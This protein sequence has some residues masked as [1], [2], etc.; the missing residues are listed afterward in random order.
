MKY[1]TSYHTHTTYCDGKS[2][3]QEMVLAAIAKGF[4]HLGFASHAPVGPG[5]EEDMLMKKEAFASYKSEILRLRQ[6]YKNKIEIFLGL[7]YD[8]YEGEG[9]AKEID[10]DEVEYFILSVH[11]LGIGKDKRPIDYGAKELEELIA[12]AGGDIREVIRRYYSLLGEYAVKESAPIVGHIDIIKKNNIGNKYFN[13]KDNWYLDIVEQCARQIKQA[14]SIVEINT[15]GVVRYGKE[16]LY[17]SDEILEM[18]RDMKIGLMLNSDAHKAENIDFYYAEMIQK[19][20][21]MRINELMILTKDG[22][23]TDAVS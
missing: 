17:P 12:L 8:C 10:P 22:W 4:T 11:S 14:G 21:N 15:G 6:V 16:C 13:E 7:E 9:M 23:T 5:H 3:A 2:T 19:M 1:K 20:K 18:L